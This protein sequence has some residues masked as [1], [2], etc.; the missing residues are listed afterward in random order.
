MRLGRMTPRR[1]TWQEWLPGRVRPLL[2]CPICSR[3]VWDLYFG[4]RI[5]CRLCL[6]LRYRQPHGDRL[7]RMRRRL[8]VATRHLKAIAA[9]CGCLSW[10]LSATANG[11][12]EA[13]VRAIV[14]ALANGERER[15]VARAHGMTIC[16]L[17]S[18]V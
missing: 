4:P 6:R 10:S 3:L 15:D 5:A 13:D 11:L 12:I 2:V 7:Y 16:D 8:G 14:R 9:E 17:H 18:I 1:S